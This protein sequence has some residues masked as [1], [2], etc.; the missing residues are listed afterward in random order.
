M[1]TLSHFFHSC[2]VLP[3]SIK[4]HTSKT[5]YLQ[6][7]RQVFGSQEAK[8]ASNVVYAFVCKKKIPRVKSKSVVIYIGQTKQNLSSR[9]MKYAEAFCS[10]VNAPLYSYII[11]QY[12]GI[13]IAYLPVQ[14]LKQVEAELLNDYYKLHK[15][16]PPRNSQRR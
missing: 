7:F 12:G 9:Y 14:S 10:G 6:Q 11:A 1:L 3:N 8:D 4:R 2:S 5:D 16:Y 15:E 13:R